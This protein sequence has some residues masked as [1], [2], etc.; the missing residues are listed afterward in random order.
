MM[1]PDVKIIPAPSDSTYK[2]K[3]GIVH[4]NQ[5]LNS[6]NVNSS[7]ENMEQSKNNFKSNILFG[8]EVT[9]STQSNATTP[10]KTVPPPPASFI[11]QQQQQQQQQQ[12][13]QT[14]VPVDSSSSSYSHSIVIETPVLSEEMLEAAAVNLL[15]HPSDI[16][17][18][19]IVGNKSIETIEI[20][21]FKVFQL[22]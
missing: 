11:Q 9:Q 16:Q 20:P 5:N 13:I 10:V 21:P 18:K 3:R 4:Q 14:A 8:N 2:D 1:S 7:E 22:P 6:S 15:V 17:A 12:P 19:P